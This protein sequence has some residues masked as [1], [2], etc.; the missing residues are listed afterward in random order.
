MTLSN[1]TSRADTPNNRAPRPALAAA[2]AVLG[3]WAAFLVP[4][5]LPG[6]IEGLSDVIAIGAPVG[7]GLLGV[8]GTGRVVAAVIPGL[9]LL[10]VTLVFTAAGP[11]GD[12]VVPGGLKSDPGIGV[13]GNLLLF[14]AVIGTGLAVA[15]GARLARVSS[16]G[17][18]PPSG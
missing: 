1:S 11:G 2:G 7:L 14:A 8:Y 3:L 10:A 12:L 5:R 4:A 16:A 15:I 18:L 6:G 9:S 13:V 17:T